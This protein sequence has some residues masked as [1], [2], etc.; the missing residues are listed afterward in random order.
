[1]LDLITYTE[2]GKCDL[3]L[4]LISCKGGRVDKPFHSQEIED[5]YLNCDH[6]NNQMW[7]GRRVITGA[8]GECLHRAALLAT[9]MEKERINK[10]W[11]SALHN[12]D[13]VDVKDADGSNGE[14]LL[15]VVE[16]ELKK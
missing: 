16:E 12:N 3:Q 9:K 13:I 15:R 14:F 6:I 7:Q 5:V 10:A 8:C 11:L 2:Y 1:M 4:L